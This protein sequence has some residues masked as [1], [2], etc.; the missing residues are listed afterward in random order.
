MTETRIPTELSH[1]THDMI[2][3]H[4]VARLND[5]KTI[6]CGTIKDIGKTTGEYG[7]ETYLIVTTGE[8]KNVRLETKYGDDGVKNITVTGPYGTAS[9]EC[10]ISGGKKS[11]RRR[12]SFRKRRSSRKRRRTNKRLP[13]Y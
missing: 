9:K 6:V 13:K 1:V 3:D 8:G 2:G 7:E 12:R 4:I 5:E 10:T 11:R